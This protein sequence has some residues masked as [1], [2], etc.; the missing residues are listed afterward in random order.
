M[1]DFQ[2]LTQSARI[3]APGPWKSRAAGQLPSILVCSSNS[4]QR[5]ALESFIQEGFR[6]THGARVRTFMPVLLGLQAA[7]GKLTAAA[8]FRSATREPLYLE[9]YFGEPIEAILARQL[10][11]RNI[12]RGEIAEIGNFAC[13]DCD[14][15][16]VMVDVLATFLMDQQHPWAVFTAT[17]T[18]RHIMA[19]LGI[20]LYE[21]GP[22]DKSRVVITGDD[23]GSYYQAD[24]KV[25]LGY[26]G[27][28]R[29]GGGPGGSS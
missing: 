27:D 3:R 26:V 5:H 6:K 4:P 18:V 25:M 8:G 23:W 2:Q 1:H 16:M 20:G 19:R 12:A 17:G 14:T 28:Y 7:D 22:A 9:Q 13:R 15:A 11:A 21:L 24:P 10:P 29:A